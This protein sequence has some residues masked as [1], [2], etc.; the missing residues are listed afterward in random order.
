MS[1]GSSWSVSSSCNT[2]GRVWIQKVLLTCAEDSN[3]VDPL[4]GL[5]HRRYVQVLCQGVNIALLYRSSVKIPTPPSP[6]GPLSRLQSVC[7]SDRA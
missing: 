3:T 7:L 4:A 6:T 2:C 1:P 5:L